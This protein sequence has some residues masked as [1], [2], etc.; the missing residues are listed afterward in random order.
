MGQ[1]GRNSTG[2]LRSLR[3]GTSGWQ[4][5]DWREPVYAGAPQRE[6]L[7]LYASTFDTV[8]VNATFYRLPAI[9]AVQHWA[10]R[11]PPGFVFAVKASRYLTHVKRLRD[12]AEPVARLMSRLEPLRTAR[13]LGPILVQLPPDLPA[14]PELLDATLTEFPRDVRV[15][16]EPRHPS[17]FAPPTRE[18]LERH[19][20]ALVWADRNGV[21]VSPLWRTTDWCYLRMHHGRDTWSYDD[22]TLERWAHEVRAVGK[23]YVYF[24]NDRG[25]AAVRDA[26][27][28][29]GLLTMRPG[30]ANGMVTTKQRQAARRNVTKAQRA[31]A[32]KRT[33]AQL[34]AAN[35]PVDEGE[36]SNDGAT[37]QAAPA[38]PE[39]PLAGVSPTGVVIPGGAPPGKP[40]GEVDTRTRGH[41]AS[42][43]P[44]PEPNERNAHNAD[45][46]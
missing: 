11:V 34:P 44:R 10:E 43:R 40:D 39:Q 42:G 1:L 24:N 23:A 25:A 13:S 21:A 8:E 36:T 14:A 4:Y 38:T 41:N 33:I 28:F 22:S 35:Q 2:L 31:A 30:T 20:A 46:R 9:D 26:L 27:A 18:V 32:S 19:D 12:P 17:W 16:V 15:A 37:D 29:G 5:A 3:V 6:W 45:R 7:E